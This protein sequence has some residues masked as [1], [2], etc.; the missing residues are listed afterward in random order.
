MRVDELP[1]HQGDDFL[2]AAGCGF[3]Q[4]HDLHLPALAL[5][6]ARNH[7]EEVG[8]KQR[9]LLAPFTAADLDDGVALVVR[10]LG[11]QQQIDLLD[12]AAAFGFEP[13]QL[14]L[15]QLAKLGVG[16]G[17][18]VLGDAS[19]EILQSAER[20][21]H[22]LEIR[23]LLVDLLQPLGVGQHLLRAQL[24]VQLLEALL[25]GLQFFDGEHDDRAGLR[26]STTSG[27]AASDPPGRAQSAV[28][29]G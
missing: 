8:R 10:I 16:H 4:V 11:Q 29:Q 18:A 27:A 19:V 9:S 6:I 28:R 1:A 22:G 14:L 2:E 5:G 3:A 26:S 20:A 13:G 23:A 12:H 21:H 15:D 24:L 25:Y 7:P 17:F